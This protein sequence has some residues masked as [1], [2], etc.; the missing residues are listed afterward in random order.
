MMEPMRAR[1][2]N[3]VFGRL[4]KLEITDGAEVVLTV[5]SVFPR[6]GVFACNAPAA[7]LSPAAERQPEA[8]V[9]E[10]LRAAGAAPARF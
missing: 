4:E 5:A 6:E 2:R 8:H 9:Q 7:A 10:I 3:G 1:F